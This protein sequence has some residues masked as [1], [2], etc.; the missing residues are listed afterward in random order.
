MSKNCAICG[1]SMEKLAVN[2]DHPEKPICLN[3]LNGFIIN[4]NTIEGELK[5]LSDALD[6][7]ADDLRN[8]LDKRQL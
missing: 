1:K 2:A 3:C 4:L 6:K 5:P 7:A 8:I